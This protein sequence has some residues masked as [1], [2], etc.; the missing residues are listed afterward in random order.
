MRLLPASLLLL[1]LLFLQPL[2]SR[3]Q[4]KGIITKDYS[5][6]LYGLKSP[7]NSRWLI[8]AQ[9]SRITW[10]TGSILLIEQNNKDGLADKNGTI[11]LQPAYDGI[12]TLIIN[13]H[14]TP[15]RVSATF[16]FQVRRAG[17]SGVCDTTGHFVIPLHLRQMGQFQEGIATAYDENNKYVFVTIAGATYDVPPGIDNLQWLKDHLLLASKTTVIPEGKRKRWNVKYGVVNDKGQLIVPVE[18]DH[19]EYSPGQFSLIECRKGALSGYYTTEGKQVWKASYKLATEEPRNNIPLIN[20]TGYVAAFDG[21]YWGI[22]D[23]AGN[24]FADFRYDEISQVKYAATPAPAYSDGTYATSATAPLW[25]LRSGKQNGIV[26]LDGKWIFRPDFES[27]AVFRSSYSILRPNSSKGDY[28]FVMRDKSGKFGALDPDSLQIMPFA[29]DTVLQNSERQSILFWSEKSADLLQFYDNVS[30]TCLK[31]KYEGAPGKHGTQKEDSPRY[32]SD[33]NYDYDG[34]YYG[35]EGVSNNDYTL[36]YYLTRSKKEQKKMLEFGHEDDAAKKRADFLQQLADRRYTDSEGNP[37][38][39]LRLGLVRGGG[40][41]VLHL[42]EF[43]NAGSKLHFYRFVSNVQESPALNPSQLLVLSHDSAHK[44][45]VKKLAWLSGDSR[46]AYFKIGDDHPGLINSTGKIII[47]PGFV[48]EV[49]PFNSFGDAKASH[50]LLFKITNAGLKKGLMDTA[51]RLVLDPVWDDIDEFNNDTVWIA[52]ASIP[53]SKTN[54]DLTWNLY[55][56]SDMKPLLSRDNEL[57]LPFRTGGTQPQ[58]VRTIKGYG[59]LD[60]VHLVFFT[61]TAYRDIHALSAEEQSQYYLVTTCTGK[62]GILLRDGS[63]AV[64]TVWRHV[65]KSG[66]VTV[67]TS[68]RQQ[69]LPQFVFSDGDRWLMFDYANG[70]TLSSPAAAK[71]LLLLAVL[72]NKTVE[73]DYSGYYNCARLE[74]YPPLLRDWQTD[75]LIKQLFLSG[76][77]FRSYSDRSR[78][79]SCQSDNAL[80]EDYYDEQTKPLKHDVLF[81]SDS[82]LSLRHSRRLHDGDGKNDYLNNSY[83]YETFLLTSKGPVKLALDSLFS[84]PGWEYILGNALLDYLKQNPGINANCTAPEGYARELRYS[85]SV[86]ASYLVLYPDWR[87]RTDGQPV[88]A[89]IVSIPWSTFESFYRRDL[90]R[91]CWSGKS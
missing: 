86:T 13:K 65:V 50:R 30:T 38:Y 22:I 32:I 53:H 7:D 63:F 57:L 37:F 67:R 42:Q 60:P 75:L 58:V 24:T 1:L 49:T 52:H 54:C 16:Y 15:S 20:R 70:A 19:I 34:V 25:L 47:E 61:K 11:L 8:P 14:E 40:A 18:Y 87:Y 64:D 74:Y 83:T 28:L 88:T 45:G 4:G 43:P 5:V 89:S 69:Q 33:E 78:R 91:K 71:K 3:A 26:T 51:G 39:Y 35:D 90:L 10:V 27:I 85:F 44:L 9:Y 82:C 29:Y 59:L 46:V 21:K 66:Y 23:A 62:T 31:K 17:L 76:H 41:D 68:Q 77:D 6:C 56:L 36:Y 79:C 73:S 84:R 2:Q 72:N 81:Q 48:Q 80:V 12:N 55:R